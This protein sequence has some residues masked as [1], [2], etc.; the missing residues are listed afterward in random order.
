[1]FRPRFLLLPSS[2]KIAMLCLHH[3]RTSSMVYT[4]DVIFSMAAQSCV[5]LTNH[6][7]GLDRYGGYTERLVDRLYNICSASLVDQSPTP[8]QRAW[9]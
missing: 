7:V 1:M 9:S 5:V 3:R 6:S 4:L 8:V 2:I